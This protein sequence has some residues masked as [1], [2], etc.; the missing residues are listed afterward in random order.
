MGGHQVIVKIY[1]NNYPAIYSS[2]LAHLKCFRIVLVNI[3]FKNNIL[4]V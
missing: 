4:F 2:M 3:I 1:L